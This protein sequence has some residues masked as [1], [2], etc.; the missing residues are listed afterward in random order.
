[1]SAIQSF[2]SQSFS[3]YSRDERIDNVGNDLINPLDQT[4]GD[5]AEFFDHE[6]QYWQPTAADGRGVYKKLGEPY[7]EAIDVELKYNY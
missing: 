2:N 1:M 3:T 7:R 6:T 4:A 5:D